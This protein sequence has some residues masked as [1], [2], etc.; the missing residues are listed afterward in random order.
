MPLLPQND[1]FHVPHLDHLRSLDGI[2]LAG[3]RSRA[4]A[5]VADLFVILVLVILAGL[6]TAYSEYTSG[7][8]DHVTVPFE[9]F[10]S[11][12]GVIALLLYFGLL[13]Y[14]WNGQTL[15]KRLLKI[16]VIS[17]KGH[18]LTLW[19]CLERS[20]GYGASALEGGFGFVQAVWYEN[21]QAVHDRIAETA[22]IHTGRWI[23]PQSGIS[24]GRSGNGAA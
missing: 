4:A 15:G 9:P 16:R 7:V 8:T 14:F 10:H 18:R 6:P 20:L 5:F 19:Q 2:P 13:T 12:K 17:L 3:F 1:K 11:L 23:D 21:R 24:T 22:V